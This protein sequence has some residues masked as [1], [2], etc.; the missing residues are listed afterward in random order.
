MPRTRVGIPPRPLPRLHIRHTRLRHAGTFSPPSAR[1]RLCRNPRDITAKDKDGIIF[2]LQHRDRV[3][4]IRLQ[5]PVPNMQKPIQVMNKEFPMLEYLFISPP[6]KQHEAL[7]LP[8]TFQA[9]HLRH[10]IL[11]NFA[12]SIQSSLLTTT[13]GLVTLSLGFISPSAYFHPGDLLIQ[14]SLMP[15]LETLRV[16]FHSPIPHRIVEEQLLYT[17]ITTRYTP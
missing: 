15:Q 16:T 7:L 10:F 12:F 4:R 8:K 6:A 9:P 11:K 5:I 2:G 1:Y 17:P 13:A 14:L 3:R